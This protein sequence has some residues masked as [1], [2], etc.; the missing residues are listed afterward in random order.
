[1]RIKNSNYNNLIEASKII[2]I[3]NDVSREGNALKL[4]K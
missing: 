1:M 2:I 3:E 4:K